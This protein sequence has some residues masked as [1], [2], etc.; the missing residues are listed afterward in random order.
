MEHAFASLPKLEQHTLSI[1]NAVIYI[2]HNTY[3]PGAD[4]LPTNIATNI[5]M[6]TPHTHA[7]VELFFCHHGTL[8]LQCANCRL[9]L[10]AGDLA[11]VPPGVLH[12]KLPDDGQCSW[13]AVGFTCSERQARC[14]HDLYR[15]IDSLSLGREP[16]VL[17]SVP[18]L[19]ALGRDILPMTSTASGVQELLSGMH[20][21]EVLSH[22]AVMRPQPSPD[23]L[24]S[25]SSKDIQRAAML[26]DLIT[27]Q[28][29]HDWSVRDVAAMLYVSPRQLERLVKARYGMTLHEAL[30][31]MRVK[32]ATQMLSDSALTIEQISQAVGF[33]SRSSFERNFSKA[34]GLTPLQY[35]AQQ[36]SK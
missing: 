22:I 34:H 24:L 29:I 7:Y 28:F 10:N 26:E 20:L 32:I 5:T 36:L 6:Q 14:E 8:V 15:A 30:V 35:R 33:S 12:V 3:D 17:S 9:T 27:T 11:L 19:C 31:N 18:A 13:N 2:L 21:V 16:T 1:E 23:R 25:A 4:D